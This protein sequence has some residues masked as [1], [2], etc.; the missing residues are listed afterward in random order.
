[1]A[2][3]TWTTNTQLIEYRHFLITTGSAEQKLKKLALSLI[4]VGFAFQFYHYHLLIFVCKSIVYDIQMPILFT[5]D[6]KLATIL[7]KHF[8]LS[9]E[10]GVVTTAHIKVLLINTPRECYLE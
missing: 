5:D 2:D 10:G 4:S 6:L 1:M 7:Q 3:G 9:I 8:I